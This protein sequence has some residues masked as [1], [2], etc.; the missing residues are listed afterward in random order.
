MKKYARKIG[1]IFLIIVILASIAFS[2]PKILTLKIQQE[3]KEIA[4]ESAEQFPVTVDPKR[5]LIVQN[6]QVDAFLADKHSLF[7]AAVVN[8]GDSL[9]N[10][11]KEIA[12]AIY[13]IPW[14]K[15]TASAGGQFVEIKPGLRK[16]QVANVFTSALGWNNKQRQEFT[17]PSSSTLSLLSEGLFSPGV[18][19]VTVGTKPEEVQ[20]MMNNRFSKDVLSHYGTST[21]EIL[22]LNEAL[23]IASLIQKETIGT[24]GMRLVS[25]I[26]WNRLFANM[27]LQIDATLQYAKANKTKGGVWWPTLTSKDKYIKSPYNTYLNP[28]LPPT[29]IASPSVAAVLAALN[30]IE[31]P[32]MYYFNDKDGEIH[33][34]NTYAEHVKLLKK[35]YK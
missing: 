8:T 5:K 35:Y 18:Y 13:N 1:I 19:F 21:Q 15:N 3:Q 24:D 2:L 33:C 17:N 25:G 20:V 23:I 14:Y 22:P 27:N 4:T 34:T 29:P 30:P 16:E 12:M 28:G 26:M 31:T 11:F 32:C 6:E 7:E 9:W 10:I